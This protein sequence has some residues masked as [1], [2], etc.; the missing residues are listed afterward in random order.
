MVHVHVEEMGGCWF[1]GYHWPSSV[2]RI[3]Q[4]W[5]VKMPFWQQHGD[6]VVSVS[7]GFQKSIIC[8]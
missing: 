5:Q 3:M 1:F 7:L 8:T 4:D 6:W 2:H